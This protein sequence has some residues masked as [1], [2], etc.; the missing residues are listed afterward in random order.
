MNIPDRWIADM[1]Y[2]NGHVRMELLMSD[3]LP[4]VGTLLITE[5]YG[6]WETLQVLSA[7]PPVGCAMVVRLIQLGDSTGQAPSSRA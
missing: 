5:S 1:Q 7:F 6:T 4:E 2:V 3:A